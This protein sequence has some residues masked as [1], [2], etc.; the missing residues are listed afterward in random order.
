[1]LSPIDFKTQNRTKMNCNET[2]FEM[3]TAIEAYPFS[4]VS[5]TRTMSILGKHVDEEELGLDK[6]AKTEVPMKQK[7]CSI[8]EKYSV[9]IPGDSY[10]VNVSWEMRIV[11]KDTY[12]VLESMKEYPKHLI[13]RTYGGNGYFIRCEENAYEFSYIEKDGV[14]SCEAT[15]HNSSGLQRIV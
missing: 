3:V 10:E 4:G 11:G 8:N 6:S 12:K 7:S 9:D 13:L 5:S 15:L 1:M 2:L 14:I